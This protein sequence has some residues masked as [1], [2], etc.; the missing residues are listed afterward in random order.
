MLTHR[1]DVRLALDRVA[2]EMGSEPDAPAKLGHEG[3]KAALL[4]VDAEFPEDELQSLLLRLQRATEAANETADA[5]SFRRLTL[6]PREVLNQLAKGSLRRHSRR[7]HTSLCD[8]IEQLLRKKLSGKGK[9][10]EH[11]QAKADGSHFVTVA[12]ATTCIQ[13]ADEHRP[14]AEAAWLAQE[15]VAHAAA[16]DPTKCTYE[17]FCHQLRR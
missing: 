6:T 9:R 13:A 5:S 16:A 11:S 17:A 2:W 7:A 15:C 3:V 8:R 4:R 14:S 10:Q 12:L 1:E